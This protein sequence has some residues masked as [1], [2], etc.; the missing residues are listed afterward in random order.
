MNKKGIFIIVSLLIIICGLNCFYHKDTSSLY[1]YPNYKEKKIKVGYYS[2]YPYYYKDKKGNVH[3]YYHELLDTLCSN[4]NIEYE[5]VDVNIN[6]AIEMLEN[7]EIDILMGLYN[8]PNKNSKLIY[9]DSHIEFDNRYIYIYGDINESQ[10][11]NLNDLN[12]KKFAYLD[13]DIKSEWL[14]QLLGYYDINVE[15]VKVKTNDECISLLNLKEVDAISSSK[16]YGSVE[17]YKETVKYYVGSVY[18]VGNGKS[19][20]VIKYFDFFLNNKVDKLTFIYNKYFQKGLILRNIIL[21]ALSI[22]TIV[23]IIY[24]IIY[25][26]IKKTIIKRRVTKNITEGNFLLYYQPIVDPFKN[27]EV[28]FEGLLRLKDKNNNVLSPFNFL[29]EIEKGDMFYELTLWILEKVICDYKIISNYENYKNKNF[30][31][32]LNLSFRELENTEFINRAIKL[33]ADYNIKKGSISLEII[34][35]VHARDLEKIQIAIALLK[36]SG[37]KIAIDDFGV[38]YSNLSILEEIDFDSVKLDKCFADNISISQITS[39]V[40]AFISKITLITDKILVIEGIEQKYQIEEIKKIVNKNVYI[41]GYYYSKPM[42]I[43]ELKEFSL[44]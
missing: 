1:M 23:G 6:N 4:L 40:I 38:E 5:Y 43:V 10:Y 39:E 34:E 24:V 25:P 35:K 11:A 36:E 17:A 14:I 9:S 18:I 2:Y 20:E 16:I 44:E 3:G 31:L 13:G 21:I 7:E 15:P 27:I 33:A 32:S 30:Y 8:I 22:M 26:Y 41:Q 37:Y 19:K 12:G 42:N 28:G 29:K